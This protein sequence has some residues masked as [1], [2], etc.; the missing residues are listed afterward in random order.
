MVPPPAL[1]ANPAAH[2][3]SA[4]ANEAA[5]GFEALFLAQVLASMRASAPGSGLLEDRGDSW[6]SMLDQ[7]LAVELAKRAPIGVLNQIGAAK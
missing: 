5:A 3:R 2:P 4:A 1:A 7:H 6:R